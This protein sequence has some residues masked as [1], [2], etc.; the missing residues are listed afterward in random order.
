MDI[1]LIKFV[2]IVIVTVTYYQVI[3]LG[4][5]A[6]LSVNII[7]SC[8]T[9]NIVIYTCKVAIWL[10]THNIELHHAIAEGVMPEYG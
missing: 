4:G 2:S 6:F 3:L 8:C 7:M 10:P 9:A 1:C 5:W